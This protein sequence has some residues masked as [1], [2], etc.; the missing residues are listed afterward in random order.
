MPDGR[1]VSEYTLT[2]AHGMVV[3]VITYG[4]IVRSIQ[5]PDRS[6]HKGDVVLG[7]DN[8]DGYVK[9][10]NNPYFGALVGRYANRIAYGHFTLDGHRYTLPI[11][12]PPNSLH[13]GTIGFDKVVWTAKAL[14]GSTPRLQLTHVSKDGDQ[15]YPGTLSVKVVYTLAN[16]DS[17]KID[18]TATTDKDTV[19]NLTS[20]SYFN[21]D[22]AGNS[23]ILPTRMQLFA[24]RYTPI[25]KNLIPTG[26]LASVAG[27]PLDFRHP[28]AVGARISSNNTQ[29]KYAN[30]YDHNW[31]LAH[32]SGVLG[33]AAH[34]V[35]PRSGRVLDVYTTEPG[36]QFYTGNFLNGKNIGKGGHSYPFRSA[37]CLE[38]Q[39]YPDSPNHK[40]F[41][42]TEL[43]PGQT[44][45]QTT[46]YKFS[47]GK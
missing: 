22:G 7:Y 21:L 40:N 1:A 28:T 4:G 17:L 39:H 45:R 20:H 31:V 25:N 13:G 32:P 23:T 8:L 36:L 15:G 27:T 33:H 43:K 41:P 37:F 42:T 24:N 16:D 14:S 47:T 44:Y 35:D 34:V 12:N 10:V 3:Q 18:Y 38:A 30:G 19:V 9:N 26:K 46:V 5:V 11:N 6:G 29:I 2:N